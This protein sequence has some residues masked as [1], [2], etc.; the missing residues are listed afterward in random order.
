[1][2]GLNTSRGLE[3]VAQS[4]SEFQVTTRMEILRALT[5][6]HALIMSKYALHTRPIIGLS[7]VKWKA[8]L[9]V[10]FRDQTSEIHQSP[11]SA[12]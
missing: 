7:L 3:L 6:M 8:K 12:Q 1:M 9:R 2:G 11:P 5:T 4:V 10:D